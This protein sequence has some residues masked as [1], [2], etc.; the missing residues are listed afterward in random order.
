MHLAFRQTLIILFA[1]CRFVKSNS[2]IML[3]N[4]V[5]WLSLFDCSDLSMCKGDFSGIL[6]KFWLIPFLEA[7]TCKM[8][9]ELVSGKNDTFLTY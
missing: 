5:N 6:D 1:L 2:K 9:A 8:I 7:P 4:A 3:I